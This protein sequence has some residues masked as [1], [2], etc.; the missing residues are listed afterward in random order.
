MS[1]FA[2]LVAR[3]IAQVTQQARALGNSALQRAAFVLAAALLAVAG[4]GFLLSAA[5]VVLARSLGP[6]GAGLI[7]GVAL[8]TCAAACFFY[9]R[10]RRA[11]EK[12]AMARLEP[13]AAASDVGELAPVAAPVAAFVAAYVLA[14]QL[15]RWH[16][17]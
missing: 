10:R 3:K 4:A 7:L 1:P 8:L 12:P 6:E 9:G 17:P 16:V 11:G 14:R 5:H 15:R 13:P 2:P